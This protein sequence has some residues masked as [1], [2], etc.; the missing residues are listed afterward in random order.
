MEIEWKFLANSRQTAHSAVSRCVELGWVATDDGVRHITDTYYDNDQRDVLTSG[1]SIRKRV[2][3]G[4]T[5]LTAKGPSTAIDGQ[6]FRREE[7]EGPMEPRF[8][9][10]RGLK[11]VL[12]VRNT[13]QIVLLSR[14]QVLIELALDTVYFRHQ[15]SNAPVDYQVELELKSKD[16]EEELMKLG[17]A[18]KSLNGL[19]TTTQNKYQRGMALT[20]CW[21]W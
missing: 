21:R 17:E 1:S 11:P 5:K 20:Q 3:N 10:E 7:Y 9:E 4:K 2:E 16:G 6:P 15:A 18:L 14:G 13:R 12:N 19:T 8:F